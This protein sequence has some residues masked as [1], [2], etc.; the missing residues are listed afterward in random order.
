MVTPESVKAGIAAG[1][2][3]EHVEVVGDGQH[4]QALIVSGEFAREGA[5][6]SAISWSTRRSASACAEENPRAV[7]AHADAGGVEIGWISCASPADVR[8]T[9]RCGSRARRTRR[10]PIMC[11][12]LL[13]DQR[14]ALTNVPSLVDVSTMGKLLRQM[15]VEVQRPADGAADAARRRNQRPDGVVR[16]W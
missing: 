3:C 5:A 10:L 8:C 16:S 12:A 6:C 1:L 7:D 9:A 2:A 13:T 11:A 4:F 15:G 14:V